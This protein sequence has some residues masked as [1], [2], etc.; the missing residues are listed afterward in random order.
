[1]VTWCVQ[2]L[3]GL[4]SI[5]AA[6]IS[7]HPVVLASPISQS[8][9]CN[10][11][12]LSTLLT[13]LS[14]GL[15]QGPWPYHSLCDIVWDHGARLHDPPKLSFSKAEKLAPKHYPYLVLLLTGEVASLKCTSLCALTLGKL[16]RIVSLG[17]YGSSSF[18]AFSFHVHDFH[19]MKPRDTFPI[20]L[21]QDRLL[22]FSGPLLIT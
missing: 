9:Y 22:P 7:G 21:V 1:M 4:F 2:L 20:F 3:C 12:F 10:L 14:N 16:S 5:P 13:V 19:N 17:G 11:S 8:L 6:F 15:F 18:S